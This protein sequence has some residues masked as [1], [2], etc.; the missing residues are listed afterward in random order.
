MTETTKTGIAAATL[1]GLTVYNMFGV[2]RSQSIANVFTVLKLLAIAAIVVAGFIYY[3]PQQVEL[4]FS[5]KQNIPDNLTTAMLTGLIG[6]LFSMGGWHHVSY[7]SGEAIN[8]KSNIPKSMFFGVLIVVLTYLLVNLAYMFLLPLEAIAQTPR[9]AEDAV[10]TLA[11]WG[12]KAVAVAIAVSIFG[13]ISIYTMTAPRIYHAMAEDGVF[14]KQLSY[15]HPKWRTP[16]TAMAIQVVWALAILLF[17]GGIFNEIITFVT[18][19]DIAFMGLAGVALFIFRKNRKE[20][21]RPI[22]AW[23]Y[24]IIPLIFVV[25]SFAFAI[26]T[27]LEQPRQAVPGLVLLGIGVGV[28]YLFKKTRV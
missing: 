27:L 8:A 13:T 20:M 18:F 17:F 15:V 26:N 6:V 25:I 3:D 14:F 19:L 7:L 24:P 21:E 2:N 11:P 5:L 22:R 1:I 23:G 9:V 10:S 4:D 12:G 16:A 28:F